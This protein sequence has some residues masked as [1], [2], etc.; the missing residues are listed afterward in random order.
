MLSFG[1]FQTKLHWAD[2]PNQLQLLSVIAILQLLTT[3]LLVSSLII[4]ESS[5]IRQDDI[6]ICSCSVLSGLF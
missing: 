2:G 5:A 6:L 1:K 3:T 4:A